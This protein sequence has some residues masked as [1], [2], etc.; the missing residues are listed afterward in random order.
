MR[1]ER[2]G[3]VEARRDFIENE[4]RARLVAETPHFPQVAGMVEVHRVRG[5]EDG[6]ADDGHELAPVRLHRASQ[7][8]GVGVAPFVSDCA[9]RLVREEMPR[10]DSAEE[11]VHAIG[12]GERHAKGCVAVVA[13]L[14]RQEPV[15]LRVA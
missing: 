11:G 14:E 15:A 12:V 13:A 8:F 3:S 5:L 7:G 6:F 9:R 4:Q 1:P 2:S 10:H